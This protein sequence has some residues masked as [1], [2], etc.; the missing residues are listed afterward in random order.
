MLVGHD[1]GAAV[2][3]QC[4]LIAEERVRAVVTLS[5]IGSWLGST[6]RHQTPTPPTEVLRQ[7][8]GENFFYQLYFQE[9]GVAERELDADP[10]KLLQRLFAAAD[11]PREPPEITDPASNTGGWLPRI[12]RP[13]ESPPWLTEEDL[14]YYVREF[15]ASGFRG[16]L[17]YYRNLDRNWELMADVDQVIEQ[18][19][20]YIAGDKDGVVRG[21]GVPVPE[22]V[23]DRPEV[24]ARLAEMI[25]PRAADF[26]GVQLIPGGSHWITQERPAEVNR[27]LVDFLR[28][29]P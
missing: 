28:G 21:Q 25:S 14:D 16:M 29:L 13:T 4:T 2:A 6:S 5:K 23:T 20:L 12:G 24:A 7:T 18:P 10:R 11:T 26:R 9:P 3:W 15:E 17:N 19:A 22:V 1:W 27:L 8:H